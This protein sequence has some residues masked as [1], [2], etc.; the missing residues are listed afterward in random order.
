MGSNNIFFDEEEEL[1]I[2]GHLGMIEYFRLK[3]LF[4]SRA[5]IVAMEL[6]VIPIYF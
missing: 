1:T 2:F 5:A 3:D 4:I 6:W